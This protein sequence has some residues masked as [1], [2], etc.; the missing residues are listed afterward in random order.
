MRSGTLAVLGARS[1]LGQPLLQPAAERYARVVAF[2]RQPPVD[3][4]T[5]AWVWADP[6]T[7]E[8]PGP[9]EDWVSVAPIWVVP[10]YFSLIERSGGRRLVVLSSTSVLTK[11]SSDDPHE[12]AVVERLQTG[13]AG[14]KAWAASRD[15]DCTV[16]RP[17]LVYGYRR[18]QNVEAIARMIRRL[19]WVALPSGAHG[20]RQ[21]V[22]ADDVAAA[23]LAALARADGQRT[24]ILSGGET[25]SYRAMV[26]RIFAA[27][28]RR[29][30][31]L[32]LPLPLLALPAR[33]GLPGL[34]SAAMLRRMRE[35]LVFDH[36]AART[37]LGFEP[38]P[39]QPGPL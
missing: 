31:I 17:T 27:E 36:A 10:D 6:C 7:A 3:A 39:F 16:L 26:E 24:F 9:L 32:T 12:R 18:D 11:A 34:P 14:V 8:A 2:S 4:K 19:G 5:A 35:D 38:R 13:E 29:P 23:A 25:L 21:P 22:H 1:L 15:I 30:R 37:A 20:Q 33:L 28:G